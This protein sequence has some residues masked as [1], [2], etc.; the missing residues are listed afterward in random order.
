MISTT[1]VYAVPECPTGMLQYP[2]VPPAK[3]YAFITTLATFSQALD[4]CRNASQDLSSIHDAFINMVLEGEGEFSFRETDTFWIGA[5]SLTK[6]WTW[7]DGSKVDFSDWKRGANLGVL[8]QCG[9]MNT[10]TGLWD[11]IACNETRPYICAS[12]LFE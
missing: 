11:M 10:R 4:D 3:C 6:N 8:N 5:N 12:D 9:V 2:P 1:V 7:T